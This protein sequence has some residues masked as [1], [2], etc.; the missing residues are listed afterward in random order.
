MMDIK[1]YFKQDSFASLNDMELVKVTPG[2]AKAHMKVA[3]KHCNAVGFCQGGAL[4]T[5]ADLAFAAAVNSHGVVTVA[6]S[7]NI[8]FTRSAQVGQDI[9]AEAIEVVNHYKLPYVEVK[10]TDDEGNLM[11]MLTA[12]GY[13]KEGS[14][15]PFIVND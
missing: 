15:L 1:E 2:Y 13:R 6:A 7:S 9:Y 14:S 10:I 5:L 12:T 4:F 3:E 11:A 8:T